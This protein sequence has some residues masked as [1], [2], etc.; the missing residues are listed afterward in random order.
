[1]KNLFKTTFTVLFGLILLFSPLARAEVV[2]PAT[3]STT[4]PSCQFQDYAKALDEALKNPPKD[5]ME[6]IRAELKIRKDWLRAVLNCSS[7]ETK[8]IQGA[9]RETS[10]SDPDLSK[11]KGQTLGQL[12]DIAKY[13]EMQMSRVNDQGLRGVKDAARAIRD[14]REGNYLPTSERA[15]NIMLW[16]KNQDVFRAARTRFDSIGQSIHKL[17]LMDQDEIK[18]KYAAAE[19]SLKQA[20]QLNAD[21][22]T[23]LLRSNSDTTTET[24]KKSLDN[25]AET[26]KSFIDLSETIKKLLPI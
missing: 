23:S 2:S 14:W 6:A 16:N 5:Y 15:A 1:M 26:Y 3:A 7:F 8:K 20:E 19:T 13:Y 21:S 4:D 11:L 25:L 12:D 22:K 17:K 24:I 10:I 9:L 18:D